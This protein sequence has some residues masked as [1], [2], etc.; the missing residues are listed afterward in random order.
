MRI[1]GG[2]DYYDVGLS[3]GIDP[4]ITL[5]RGQRPKTVDVKTA[6]GSLLG[7]KLT[8]RPQYGH[9]FLLRNVAVAFCT[10]VYRGAVVS[11]LSGTVLDC[12]WS[13]DKIRAWAEPHKKQFDVAIDIPWYSRKRSGDPTLEDWFE[14]QE[15]PAVLRDYMIG[16]KISILV[17][18]EPERHWDE[19]YFKINPI[20]LKQ[21]GFAK[22]LGPYEAFQELSMWIGGVLGGNSP[23]TVE[24]KSDKVLIENHGFDHVFSFRGP[25]LK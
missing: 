23:E 22:A 4:L 3:L 13:A 12:F 15:V 16:K 9:E 6:G 14:P 1:I 8:L 19:H 17:E 11:S 5:V 7:R 18:E 25:R 10:K 21:L 24:I 20:G 2:H